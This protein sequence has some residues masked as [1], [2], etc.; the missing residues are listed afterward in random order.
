M[1]S[2]NAYL[3]YSAKSTFGSTQQLSYSSDLTTSLNRVALVNCQSIPDYV[4]KNG[5]LNI[6]LI[7]SLDLTNVTVL[8]DTVNYSTSTNTTTKIDPQK[9]FYLNYIIDPKGQL[10]GK[11]ICGINNYQNYI[12][13]SRP[14]IFFSN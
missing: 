11:S 5:D 9:D 8:E 7:T 14:N 13:Y 6:N 1:S 2:G 3:S 4:I 10:F 12:V